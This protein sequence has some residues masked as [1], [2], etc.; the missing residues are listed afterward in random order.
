MK[1]LYFDCPMGAAGD[2]LMSAL[3]ELHP[4]P[5]GFVSHM[6]KIG[7]NGIIIKSER[8]TSYGISGTRTR[9]MID[10]HEEGS[11]S[12]HHSSSHEHHHEHR[13]EHEHEHNYHH[14]HQNAE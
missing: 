6:N 11:H 5:A 14:H 12:H 7:F 9:V 4:D 3:I 8:T 10:G 2:M 13:H 1:T